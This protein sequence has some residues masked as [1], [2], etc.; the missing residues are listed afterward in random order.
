VS[1]PKKVKTRFSVGLNGQ[2]NNLEDL[3]GAFGNDIYE[4]FAPAP[5]E[6]IQTGRRGHVPVSREEIKRQADFAHAHG[7]R[8]NVLM[9]GPCQG[10][11][12]FTEEFCTRLYSF[13]DFL[14]ENKVDCVTITNP[15][16]IEMVHKHS[17]IEIT[18]GSWSDISTPLKARRFELLG[19]STIVPIDTVLKSVS[20]LKA[21]Q[22][23]IHGALKIIVNQGCVFYCDGFF[24]HI[25]LVA[26]S[27]VMSDETMDQQGNYLYPINRC[28]GMR[29][30]NPLEFF[31]SDFI[32]P[33]DLHWYED[34]G[35]HLFKIAGRR[36]PTEWMINT[37]RAYL[38]RSYEG[39]VFDLFSQFVGQTTIDLPNKELDGWF[40]FAGDCKDAEAFMERCKEFCLDRHLERHFKGTIPDTGFTCKG[41]RA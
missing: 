11:L 5:A 39:N 23:G 17:P 13:L 40:E 34:A 25:N 33:E 18:A 24:A 7:V 31:M 38:N 1:T 22:S 8:Y 9:N 2:P 30:V 27:S 41:G 16:I 14:D 36:A 3:L 21:M 4:V 6:V 19:A 29:L 35:I 12:E 15:F 37:L 26:H 10:G 20:T 28:R 32:R